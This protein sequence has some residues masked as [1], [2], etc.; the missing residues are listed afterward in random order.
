[1]KKTPFLVLFFGFSVISNVIRCQTQEQYYYF[2]IP[3]ITVEFAAESKQF[4]EREYGVV[5]DYY[6]VPAGIFSVP[7]G[8]LGIE[9]IVLVLKNICKSDKVVW[10]ENFTKQ[11]ADAACKATRIH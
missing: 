7:K 4:F 6:C 5:V 3:N 8:G 10:K 1:M 9:P 11:D 2:S